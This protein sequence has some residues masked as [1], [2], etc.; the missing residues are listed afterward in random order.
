MTR[1]TGKWL[2]QIRSWG[3]CLRRFRAK[4]AIGQFLS[5]YSQIMEKGWVIMVRIITE[6]SCRI[7]PCA[8]RGSWS[9][10][11]FHGEN[12]NSLLCGDRLSGPVDFDL[13]VLYS[14][15]DEETWSGDLQ[16]M[17]RCLVLRREK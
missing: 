8:F 5:L 14:G 1:M 6:S 11:V 17:I 9:D 7:L 12:E 4:T 10:P 15:D 13:S 2:T 3:G 16:Q